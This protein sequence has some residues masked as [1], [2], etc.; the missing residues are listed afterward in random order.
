MVQASHTPT[1]VQMQVAAAAFR[2]TDAPGPCFQYAW[3]KNNNKKKSHVHKKI[4]II[5]NAVMTASA[6]ER[7]KSDCE[8]SIASE[9]RLGAAGRSFRLDFASLYPS[10]CVIPTWLCV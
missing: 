4:L 10:R 5:L 7:R 8:F 2:A 1:S 3:D 9:I 6:R